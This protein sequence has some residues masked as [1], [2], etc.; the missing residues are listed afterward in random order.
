MVLAVTN[1]FLCMEPFMDR[2]KKLAKEET[3]DY[4]LLREKDL[5]HEQY[6][7]LAWKCKEILQGSSVRLVLHSDV[8]AAM[9]LSVDAIHFPFPVFQKKFLLLPEEQRK[10]FSLIGVS[11]HSLE[12]AVFVEEHGGSYV[13]AGHIFATDCKK[14]LPPRG[15]EFLKRICEGVNIPVYGIGG[16]N[17]ENAP[18]VL[19]AGAAGVAVM[20]GF[21]RDSAVGKD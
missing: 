12:E 14:G 9:E 13:T 8:E 5:P 19:A 1:R 10:R 16:I 11:T 4:L 21:M 15:L 18:A 20:S 3:A 7:E 17:K 6:C 2:I